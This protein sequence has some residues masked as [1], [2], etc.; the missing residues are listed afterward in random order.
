MNVGFSVSLSALRIVNP[1]LVVTRDTYTADVY[2]G[3]G[4]IFVRNIKEI[5]EE[6]QKSVEQS[7]DKLL[8]RNW[9]DIGR[10]GEEDFI[11]PVEVEA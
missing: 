4:A 3:F 11:T 1:S 7:T 8:E 5:G 9:E 2:Q 6:R 10:S